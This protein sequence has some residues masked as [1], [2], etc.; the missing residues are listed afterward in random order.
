MKDGCAFMMCRNAAWL[1][2]LG[3]LYLFMY[4]RKGISA[5]IFMSGMDSVAV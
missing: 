3:F 5:A 4:H 1:R 2:A